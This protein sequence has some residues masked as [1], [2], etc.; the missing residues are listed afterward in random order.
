MAKK[1]AAKSECVQVCV[2][3]RPMSSKEK[4]DRRQQCVFVN[5]ERGEIIVQAAGKEGSSESKKYTYDYA[6]PATISQEE[7]YDRTARPIVESCMEGY[8]GEGF[9]HTYYISG[10]YCLSRFICCDGVL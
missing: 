7:V 3:L 5:A 6:F 2:R 10:V 8:N 9:Y 1:K 4:R